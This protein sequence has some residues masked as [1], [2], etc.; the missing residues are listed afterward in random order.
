MKRWLPWL[1]LV[2]AALGVLAFAA[3][4]YAP[5]K[6]EQ[7]SA[8]VELKTAQEPRK[9]QAP[10]P[11][12]VPPAKAFDP[13]IIEREAPAAGGPAPEGAPWPDHNRTLAF[14]ELRTSS[15]AFI[16]T[17]R[18]NVTERGRVR[19]VLDPTKSVEALKDELFSLRKG[20]ELTGGAVVQV[21]KIVRADLVAP[22]LKITAV[23]PA[24]QFVPTDSP[25]EWRWDIEADKPGKYEVKITLV[26]SIV[27]DGRPTNRL[28]RVHEE[29]VTIEITPAQQAKGFVEKYWQ[30]AMSTLVIPLG[31]W[32]W[33]R[34]KNPAE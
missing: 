33:K 7:V 22:G 3:I 24:E 1:L 20:D 15:F 6:H 16:I 14:E 29:T 27:I 21:T 17:N 32:L 12:E 23:T 34:R 26:A 13:S 5:L 19:V 2:L 8:T 30:W 31:L 9:A 10:R 25:T 4:S 18:F 11:V 28:L